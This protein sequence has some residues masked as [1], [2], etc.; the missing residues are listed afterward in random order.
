MDTGVLFKEVLLA[1]LL[2]IL[3]GIV[4]LLSLAFIR[5]YNRYSKKNAEI[6]KVMFYSF[7]VMMVLKWGSGCEMMVIL[8]ISENNLY[9]VSLYLS[10]LFGSMMC[11]YIFYIKKWQLMSITSS[12][13]MTAWAVMIFILALVNTMAGDL[14]ILTMVTF[15]LE[16]FVWTYHMSVMQQEFKK[17]QDFVT[18]EPETALG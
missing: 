12:M 11:C 6:S 4:Y 2:F 14:L 1:L 16:L 5:E 17:S 9:I 8:P 10:Y 13:C 7:M 18:V 3:N 15:W